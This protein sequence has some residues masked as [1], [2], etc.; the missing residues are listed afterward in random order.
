MP[1]HRFERSD[2]TAR[3][4]NYL[5][6]HEKGSEISYRELSK[7]AQIS[8]TPRSAKLISA[9]FILERDHNAIWIC[10]R[11]KVGLR[12]LNDQ[13]IA[14]RLPKWWLFG[15]RNKLRRGGDQA[16]VVEIGALDINQQAR[17]SIDCIQ[18]ELAFES[19]SK[20]TRRRM[21]RIAR[22]TS[23][24]LPQFSVLEW[25]ISLMPRKKPDQQHE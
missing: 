3:I 20:A 6:S 12:R 24:D 21:E 10:V 17:F 15:A 11:P 25:A 13:E 9:R 2:T 8:I 19:L 1:R 7:V 14:D 18:R 16:D 23:N 5:A 22:G 4:V